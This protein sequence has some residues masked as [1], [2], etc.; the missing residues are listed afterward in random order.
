MNVKTKINISTKVYNS[1][2]A[3][4]NPAIYL[5]LTHFNRSVLSIIPLVHEQMFSIDYL[6]K[7]YFL[8][9]TKKRLI[10]ASLFT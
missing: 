6:V 2:T 5:N 4:K 8:F 7:A 1:V 3:K 10:L 9:Q